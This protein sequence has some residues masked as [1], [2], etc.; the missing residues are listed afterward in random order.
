MKRLTSFLTISFVAV[1]T[2]GCANMQAFN[3]SGIRTIHMK[4]MTRN[5]L[6]KHDRKVLEGI[7][8]NNETCPNQPEQ[9]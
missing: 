7:V 5:Y 2:A 9:P 3:C 6:L 4:P 8:G 1:A